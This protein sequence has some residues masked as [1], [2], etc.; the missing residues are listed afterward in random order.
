MSVAVGLNRGFA[1]A[2]AD[3][4]S[5]AVDIHLVPESRPRELGGFGIRGYCTAGVRSAGELADFLVSSL[6]V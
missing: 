1:A 5:L 2:V 3:I 6:L 4:R